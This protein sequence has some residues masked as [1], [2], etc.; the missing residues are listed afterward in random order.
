MA[1]IT[2]TEYRAKRLLIG[3][4]YEGISVHTENHVVLPLKGRWVVKVDQGIKRRFKN[5]LLA[6]D[7]ASADI[8]THLAGWRKDG[9]TSFLIEPCIQH[10]IADERYISFERVREG[11][12]ILYSREGGV[13]IESKKGGTETYIVSGASDSAEVAGKTGVPAPFLAD[14]LA[15][16]EKHFFAFLEINPLVIRGSDVAVL[17]AA[18]LVDGAGA[19]FVRDSW[20]EDD[21][22]HAHTLYG[23]EHAIQNLQKTTSASVKL[24]VLNP[25]GNIFF[26]LSGG[27]GSIVVVDEAALKGFGKSIGNYGEYSGAPT[28]EETYL[29]AR[30]VLKL[31]LASRAKKKALVIAGGVANF[32]DVGSTFAGIIDAL[33]EVAP[34][35]RKN[36]VKVFVRRGGPNEEVGLSRMKDFLKK[37]DLFGSL[38]GSRAPL[39]EAVDR[40]LTYLGT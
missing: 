1:R 28:R 10:N 22:V 21:V 23:A 36:N 18:L 9:Y 26:L 11:I 2:L 24:K 32:T 29:Y 15:A 35:L 16:F 30:E 13:A 33:L 38:G 34:A 27:G 19:F 31:L 39:T 14:T 25:N 17:D 6:V 5:G 8:P 3:S 20:T 12:R 37:E 4:S 40:A 7:I